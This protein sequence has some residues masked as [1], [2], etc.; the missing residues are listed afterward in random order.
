M[1]NCHLKEHLQ[2]ALENVPV[3][4][5]EREPGNED[6]S[7]KRRKKKSAK[8]EQ[9]LFL[10]TLFFPRTWNCSFLEVMIPLQGSMMF[11]LRICQWCDSQILFALY[12]AVFSSGKRVLDPYS[13]KIKQNVTQRSQRFSSDAKRRDIEGK[14]RREKT[15]GSGRCE[16]HYHATIGVNQHH[17]ID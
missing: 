13:E 12:L 9:V 11:F 2:L 15:S 7:R 17:E 5:L 6:G 10:R 3:F 1:C 14:M 8:Q 16:S 4:Q